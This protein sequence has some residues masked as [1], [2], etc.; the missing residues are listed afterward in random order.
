MAHQFD[1]DNAEYKILVR[2]GGHALLTEDECRAVEHALSEDGIDPCDQHYLNV[3][4]NRR[5]KALEFVRSI[6]ATEALD[7]YIKET[8]NQ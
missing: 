6:G 3:E 5:Q 2:Q 1:L 8:E 4:R 7:K